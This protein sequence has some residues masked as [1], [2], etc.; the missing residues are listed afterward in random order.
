MSI[1]LNPAVQFFKAR[2]WTPAPFQ[3]EAW[4]AY[5]RGESGIINATTG[6]GKTY[7]TVIGPL[8]ELKESPSEKPF[9]LYISPL[10]ALVRDIEK[11]ITEAAEYLGVTCRIESRHGDLSSYQ[12][13][14]QRRNLPTVLVTTPESLALLLTYEEVVS[15]LSGVRCVVIDE[16]HEF[17]T[18]K[19]SSLLELCLARLRGVSP[20]LRTWALSATFAD[21]E[22]AACKAVGIGTKPRL[23]KAAEKRQVDIRILRPRK[24]DRVPWAGH[25]GTF[26]TDDFLADINWQGTN[27]LFTNTRSQAER[28]FSNLSQKLPE[29]KCRLMAIHHG[30]IEADARVSVEQGL[31][32]GELKLVIATSSLDLGI[33]YGSVD[34]I[35]QVGSPK[36]LN[37]LLQRAGR[38]NHRP[39]EASRICFIPT[40]AFESLE[41][42]AFHEG[43]KRELFESFEAPEKPLDVLAQFLCIRALGGGFTREDIYREITT[44]HSYRA[45]TKVDIDRMLTF[46]VSGGDA[47][48][49]YRE[50]KKLQEERGRF[51]VSDRRIAQLIRMNIGTITADP[52]I[53][54]KY[55]NGTK[56][57]SMEESIIRYIRPG[58]YFVFAGKVLK[59][60]KI[61]ENAAIVEPGKAKHVETPRWL[62]GTLPFSPLLAEALKAVLDKD[63]RA[64]HFYDELLVRIVAQQKATSH[65]PTSKECLVETFKSRE[66]QHL[67]IYPFAGEHMNQALG[68]L[69]AYRL[70]VRNASTLGVSANDYGFEIV[71]KK[72]FS[73]AEIEAALRAPTGDL[74][75]EIT[76]AVNLAEVKKRHFREI[77]RIAGLIQQNYPGQKKKPNQTQISAGLLFD[78][79]TRFDPGNILLSQCEREVW[80]VDFQLELMLSLLSSLSKQTLIFKELARP[81]AFAVPLMIESFAARI[82]FESLGVRLAAAFGLA[83]DKSSDIQLVDTYLP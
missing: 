17:L 23:I 24:I 73:Q 37:R 68:M 33:D 80:E 6:G 48:Q 5:L 52:S 14:K 11:R 69:I 3:W 74:R 18:N 62:G 45:L 58:D 76:G 43:L 82:P 10:R 40:H 55:L 56:L 65:Y 50:F 19:R 15:Q 16:L 4:Q 34:Q 32:R 77:A 20:T 36:A 83:A 75:N 49:A 72:A 63:P 47:L 51:S 79:L 35:Y 27:L 64:F 30:S 12:K 61:H 59:L 13:Q 25:V 8:L 2:G 41:F 66:G 60:K 67:F 54:I 78:V 44:A 71:S 1:S 81:S 70:G 53:Q 57:G 31:S 38:S 29:D 42:E 9:L 39:G 22:R 28:W 21:L 7:A 26:M 46:L